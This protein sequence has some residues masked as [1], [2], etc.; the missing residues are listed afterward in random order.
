MSLS[1]LP[2]AIDAV[3]A[4]GDS[5]DLAAAVDDARYSLADVSGELSAAEAGTL[6]SELVIAAVGTTVALHEPPGDADWHW[7]VTGSCGRGEGLPGS[8]V[9]TLVAFDGD[10][11]IGPKLRDVAGDVHQHLA[12]LGFAPDGNGATANRARCCRSLGDWK[13]SI[14]RWTAEPAADRGVVMTGL[15]ADAAPVSRGSTGPAANPLAD[16]LAEQLATR[17]PVLTAMARDASVVRESIPTRLTI[18][19]RPREGVSPKASVID[20]AVRM[21]RW[22]ALTSG[23][24]VRLSSERLAC[25]SPSAFQPQDRETLGHALDA[26]SAIRWTIRRDRW[27][28]GSFP[29]RVA[30]TSL[31]PLDR[32]RLRGAG[33]DVVGIQRVL[34]YLAS[35]P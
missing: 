2:S 23:S 5:D 26:A 3:R 20:P 28:D 35:F 6:W 11:S 34:R 21:A 33:R 22:N 17:P 12:E 1:E 16:A 10:E 8:D 24:S 25:A 4:A 7:Y 30:L 31:R 19:T 29:D 13:S 14:V 32:A 15:V 9:E 18:L 27:V